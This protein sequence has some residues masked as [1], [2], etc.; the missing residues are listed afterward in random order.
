M[1]SNLYEYIFIYAYILYIF[2]FYAPHKFDDIAC[3][4]YMSQQHETCPLPINCH[5]NVISDLSS[6]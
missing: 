4:V 2:A 1:H 3:G 5:N 6:V